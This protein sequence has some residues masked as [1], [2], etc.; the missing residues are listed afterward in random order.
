MKFK[1]VDKRPE[2]LN[3][4]SFFLEPDK[5]F[6]YFA[7][8]FIYCTLPKLNYPDSKGATRSF[9]V[10][11]SPTEG[12]LIR[13]TTKIRQ[14]SGYKKTLDTLVMGSLIEVDGPNGSFILDENEKG[15][16][17]FIA[18]GIGITP[19]RSMLKYV[20]DKNL[21]FNL[22]LVYSCSTL[23]ELSFK[24]EL[25]HYADLS[26][27]FELTFTISKPEE[28]KHKWKGHIGR[29]DANLI[30]KVSSNYQNPTYWICGAGS[31]VDD[32]AMVLKN[33]GINKSKI[34][35]DKFTGY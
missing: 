27:N 32:M 17:I 7:G 14:E 13:F 19:F 28:S 25:E 8:Q 34:K 30:N 21:H 29:I 15:P 26:S 12:P 9:T 3:T 2:S 6:S 33:L 23:E 11:S 22:Y 4:K 18:G 16:H 5:K 1:I 10:S 24:N 31:F 35:S 20:L